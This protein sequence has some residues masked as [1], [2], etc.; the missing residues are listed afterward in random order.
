M[1]FLARS[2]GTVDVRVPLGSSLEKQLAVILRLSSS[3]FS[4]RD[5]PAPD[6]AE[7]R[8]EEGGP[9]GAPGGRRLSLLALP[10]L[11]VPLE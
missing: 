3:N 1:R 9:P 11:P 8:S 5:M 6:G 7:E 4:A 2:A 10:V